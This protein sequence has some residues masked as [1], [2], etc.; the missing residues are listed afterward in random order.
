MNYLKKLKALKEQK[1]E[2]KPTSLAVK[3]AKST[4]DS[5]G[6]TTS[7]CFSEKFMQ[8]KNDI[9]ETT[10]KKKFDILWNQATKLADWIDDEHSDV[11]W[12]ERTKYVSKLLKISARIGELEILIQR[13]QL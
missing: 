5:F 9:P 6:S 3:T 7:S 8:N 10:L 12:Q 13:S 2:N 1:L 11:P 4:Y